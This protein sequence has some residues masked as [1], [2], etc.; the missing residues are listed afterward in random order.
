[1]IT[2]FTNKTRSGPILICFNYSTQSGQ[3][4]NLNP[5]HRASSIQTKMEQAS[6][7]YTEQEH[8]RENHTNRKSNS[9]KRVA[10]PRHTKIDFTRYILKRHAS[11]PLSLHCQKRQLAVK[12]SG[13]Q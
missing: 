2:L 7:R 9:H 10:K 8:G 11:H 6:V 3:V 5:Q 1:M 4:I 12:A 13:K